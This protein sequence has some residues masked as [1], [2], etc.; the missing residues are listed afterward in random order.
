[1]SSTKGEVMSTSR[2]QVSRSILEYWYSS[3]DDRTPLDPQ[4]QVEPFRTCFA[5][6][7]GKQPAIDAEIRERFEPVLLAATRDGRD[8][9]WEIAEWQRAPLGLVALVILLDQFPRNIYRDTA[10][11]YA[12]DDL[13]L[14]VATLAVREYEAAPLLL[15]QRM[16]L[17]MPF[18][19]VE[20]LTLQQAMVG[21]F[22]SLVRLAEERSPENVKFFA[23]GLDY[24]KK[25]RDI[26]E[27]YGRFPHRNLIL[28][29][30][31]TPPE[32]EFL[33]Q[34]GSSF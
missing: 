31:S 27:T 29:R 22:E 5:R 7:Y 13:A 32:L 4:E 2:E 11:M 1:M 23:F 15:V 24:A 30:T 3:L 25:H 16:F 6:W 28:G 14:S 33:E 19:H 21:K 34:A 18:M 8:W 10:A 9:D 17:Y 20:N 26:V 12:H